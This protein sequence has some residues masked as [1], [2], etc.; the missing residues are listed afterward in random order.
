MYLPILKNWSPFRIDALGLVT[1]L[2]VD[3]LNIALGR[4]VRNRYT[5]YLPLLGGFIVAQDRIVK[6]LPGFVVYNITDGVMATD[7]AGWFSRWLSVNLTWSST[8][9]HISSRRSNAGNLRQMGS[10]LPALMAL[11]PTLAIT[12]LAATIGDWW[13]FANTLSMLFS[14]FVRSTVVGQNRK[15]LNMAAAKAI[16]SS[17]EEVKTYWSTPDG[18]TVTIYLPRMVLL[19][20]FLTNPRP[21][22]ELLY[23]L[24]QT[25]GWI[26][27]GCHVITLGMATL[28][29]Q[30]ISV[31]LLLVASV[32]VARRIGDDEDSIG[33]WLKIRREFREG[34]RA[35][36]YGRLN[37]T[38][39]EED[40]MIA[41]G[42]MPHRSNFF[43]WTNFEECKKIGLETGFG[44]WDKRMARTKVAATS[45]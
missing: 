32:L 2:G 10:L 41:W 19:N 34:S 25:I 35:A 12:G 13:G 39:K 42:I 26:A 17:T 14:V 1:L 40:S 37:L 28:V 29:I 36:A 11:F 16:T 18:H 6:P 23:N 5:E 31:T 8:T 4:L 24:T 30:I 20:C 43:W 27:F 22:K 33:S 15:A 3:E 7:V 44:D 38:G 9:L 21:P 45:L